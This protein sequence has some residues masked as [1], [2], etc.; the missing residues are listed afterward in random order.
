MHRSDPQNFL[1]NEEALAGLKYTKI[2]RALNRATV[3]GGEVYDV[4]SSHS[5]A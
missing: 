5:S 3:T 2:S 4:K 1:S